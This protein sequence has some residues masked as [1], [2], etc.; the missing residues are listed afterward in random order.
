[1]QECLEGRFL[2]LHGRGRVGSGATVG[3][4]LFLVPWSESKKFRIF[5]HD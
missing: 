5:T 2:P 3:S 4:V 1:M